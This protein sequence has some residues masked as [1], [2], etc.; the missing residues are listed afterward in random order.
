MDP[1]ILAVVVAIIFVG[2]VVSLMPELWRKMPMDMDPDKLSEKSRRMLDEFIEAVREDMVKMDESVRQAVIQALIVIP[3]RPG[4]PAAA[5]VNISAS[6]A[7]VGMAPAPEKKEKPK[8][9]AKPL[10]PAPKKDELDRIQRAIDE[11]IG[12][13]GSDA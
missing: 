9:K 2:A 10:Y 4:G 6:M 1:L 11:A 7:P 12:G 8:P 5:K 13:G 3:I